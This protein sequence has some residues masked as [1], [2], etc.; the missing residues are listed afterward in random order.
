[1]TPLRLFKPIFVVAAFPKLTHL[2]KTLIVMVFHPLGPFY[3]A[4]R[5]AKIMVVTFFLVVG[6]AKLRWM[7]TSVPVYT[8]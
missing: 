8:H 1:M 4:S 3:D 2:F 6:H 7:C 5:G